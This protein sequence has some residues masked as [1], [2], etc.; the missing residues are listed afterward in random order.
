MSSSIKVLFIAD[1]VGEPGLS[2]LQTYLP[3]LLKKYQ[4]DFTIANGENAHEGKGIN[5]EIIQQLYDLGIQVITGG[6][7]SFDKWKIFPY[8]KKDLHLLRPMNYPRGAHGYG[9]GIF[10]I[11]HTDLKIGVLNLQG[12]TFLPA[13]ED[14]FRTADYVIDKIRQETPLIFVDFHA[15]ATAEKWAMAWYLDGRASALVGT[16]THVPTN[17]AR[18]FPEGLGYVTDAGMTGSFNSVL[19]MDKQTAI[20]RFLL[21]TPHKYKLARGMNRLCAVYFELDTV[22]G[23]SDCIESIIFPEFERRRTAAKPT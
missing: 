9:F 16:H 18:I 13:I 4:V 2:M 22:N 20:K 11:P 23:H 10:E 8:M 14:P 19:G 12:R 6:N 7:H 1:I 5:E 21:A 3:A 17:D 15:E